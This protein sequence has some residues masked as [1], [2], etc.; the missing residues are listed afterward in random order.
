M[1]II[2]P[3]VIAYAWVAAKGLHWAYAILALF[4]SGF[5]ILFIYASSLAYLVDANPGRS[6]AATAS[7]SSFR[8]FA[9]MIASQIATPLR[10]V[11]GDGGLYSIWAG[12]L[13]VTELMVL[14]VIWKGQRWREEEEKRERRQNGT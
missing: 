8:G 11:L 4:V 6:I 2:P 9:G 13:V 3:A 1:L 12:L 14:L 10:Q 7:N 5:G